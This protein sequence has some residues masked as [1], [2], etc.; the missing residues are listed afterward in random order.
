MYQASLQGQ[1]LMWILFAGQEIIGNS[2][3]KT[4][5]SG[6]CYG[7]SELW[8]VLRFKQTPRLKAQLFSS[9][10][11]QGKK[12]KKK[13]VLL[14]IEQVPCLPPTGIEAAL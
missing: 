9:F 11:G 5:H 1:M 12:K 2:Q 6:F 7:I 10:P 13:T 3:Y 4:V 14:K 8:P